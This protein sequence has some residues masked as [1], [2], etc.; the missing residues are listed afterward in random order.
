MRILKLKVQKGRGFG[1]QPDRFTPEEVEK[2]K[3]ET[4]RAIIQGNKNREFYKRAGVNL[5]DG[6]PTQNAVIL[7]KLN[8]V[9]SA[10]FKSI[11]NKDLLKQLIDLEPGL[12]DADIKVMRMIVDNKKDVVLNGDQ[13]IEFGTIVD[14]IL[15]DPKVSSLFPKSSLVFDQQIPV[16][17]F[18]GMQQKSDMTN[19]REKLL[20]EEEREKMKKLAEMTEKGQVKKLKEV[21]KETGFKKL[22]EEYKDKLGLQRK[23]SRLG[24]DKLEDTFPGL[25]KRGK[26]LQEAAD[27]INE[28]ELEIKKKDSQLALIKA[29]RKSLLKNHDALGIEFAKEKKVMKAILQKTGKSSLQELQT[30]TPNKT[31]KAL[32]KRFEDSY[33]KYD[34]LG[35]KI[36]DIKA[37]V[38]DLNQEGEKIKDEIDNLLKEKRNQATIL[39][40]EDETGAGLKRGR[41]RPRKYPVGYQKPYRPRNKLHFAQK[42]IK[43]GGLL[44][45]TS[46]LKT[47]EEIAQTLLEVKANGQGAKANQMLDATADIFTKAQ[48][49]KLYN[50]INS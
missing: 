37:D 24:Q 18:Q 17:F 44:H 25:V 38:E 27:K 19:A 3:A 32:L 7:Q 42:Q 20:L 46:Q 14:W 49:D 10:K 41:G 40:E 30:M 26:K 33:K 45:F 22:G 1:N 11:K 39:A 34:D 6:L 35:N 4:D 29:G 12:I 8:D 43:V 2:I 31:N 47:P 28:I 5:D 36:N 50:Q 15:S 23:P 21:E 9:A 16:D 13:S 48:F